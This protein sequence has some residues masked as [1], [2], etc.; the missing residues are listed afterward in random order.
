MAFPV[1]E[2][3]NQNAR[4]N[5]SSSSITVT[6][7]S[8]IETGDL[9]LLFVGY[10]ETGSS[11]TITT[12]S[13][14]TLLHKKEGFEGAACYWKI[15]VLAD[16]S[17]TDYTVSFSSATDYVAASMHRISGAVGDPVIHD[18]EIDLN[19]DNIGTD[20]TPIYT[21]D[22]TPLTN[23]S[24]VFVFFHGA[25]TNIGAVQ[26]LSGYTITP[27][28]TL[29]ERADT[30]AQGGGSSGSGVTIGVASG[31]Y[32]GTSTITSRSATFSTNQMGR[33]QNSIALVI[34]GVQN[35]TA[36]LDRINVTP[37]LYAPNGSNTATASVD[38]LDVTPAFNGLESSDT[39]DQTQWTNET[40]PSTTWT[41]EQP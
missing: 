8:G 35:A 32:S 17:A 12:P 21:T 13:G 19:G 2:S 1:V 26:T 27:T 15:A 6:A 40:K 10:Y 39:S 33:D 14:F 36:N 38:R 29:T 22:I 18:S 41:N 3:S 24:L 37:T 7:P 25:S 34:N 20:T 9:L 5:S 28:T 30:G 16:E 31:E 4:F 23:E 11:R